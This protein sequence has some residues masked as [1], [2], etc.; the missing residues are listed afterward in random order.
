MKLAA[1]MFAAGGKIYDHRRQA[2]S[3]II[4]PQFGAPFERVNQVCR[5]HGAKSTGARTYED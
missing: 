1:Y 5:F 3:K 4:W 2:L